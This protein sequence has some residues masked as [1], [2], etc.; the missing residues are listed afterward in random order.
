MVLSDL[1]PFLRLP[2]LIAFGGAVFSATLFAVWR[3]AGSPDSVEH[4]VLKLVA[5]AVRSRV[6]GRS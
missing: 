3:L 4:E 1:S 5:G 6:G 2:L